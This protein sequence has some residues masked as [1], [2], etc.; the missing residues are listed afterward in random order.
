MNFLSSS[1]KFDTL[2][3][4]HITHKNIFRLKNK[5]INVQECY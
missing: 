1:Y 3:I 5:E 4:F 2:F